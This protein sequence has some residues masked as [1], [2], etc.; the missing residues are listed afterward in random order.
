M[1]RNNSKIII[2]RRE[3]ISLP[4]FSIYNLDAKVDTGA[5]TS[6]LHCH[7]VETNNRNGELW[8]TFCVLDPGHPE[9]EDEHFETPVF[10]IKNI[11][12]SNGLIQERVI[13]KQECIFWGIRKHIELSLTDRSDMKYPV[14]IGRKFLSGKYIVDVSKKYLYKPD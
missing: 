6:S 13:I 2:G 5:Y 12:S 9:Y 7:S 8:V 14:L 1:S 11:K 4:E 3:K 10:A